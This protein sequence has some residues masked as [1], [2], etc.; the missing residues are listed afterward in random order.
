MADKIHDHV[1]VLDK[2]VKITAGHEDDGFVRLRESREFMK[3]AMD[4]LN[5]L[6]KDY[7]HKDRRRPPVH[8]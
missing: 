3:I 7:N 4:T 1:Q 5:M 2:L 8:N 6:S